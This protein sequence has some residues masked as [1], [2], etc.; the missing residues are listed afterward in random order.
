MARNRI[1]TATRSVTT[2]P[3][4]KKKNETKNSKKLE[5]TMTVKRKRGAEEEE[6]KSQIESVSFPA[7]NRSNEQN[8]CSMYE[9][10]YVWNAC[11]LHESS[12]IQSEININMNYT[13][14]S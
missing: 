3:Q 10:L 9:M 8:I 14:T 7:S 2:Q 6:E 4:M 12:I 13:H 1:A 5:L 11:S